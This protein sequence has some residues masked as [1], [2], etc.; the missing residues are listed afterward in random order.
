MLARLPARSADGRNQNGNKHPMQ[1]TIKKF[2]SPR[3]LLSVIIAATVFSLPQAGTAQ[4]AEPSSPRPAAQTEALKAP[5]NS[6]QGPFA[7]VDESPAQIVKI[8]ETLTGK[9]AVC[10]PLPDAKICFSSP[11]KITR[12]EA[13]RALTSLLAANGIALTPF[14]EK[15]FKVSEASSVSSQSPLWLEKSALDMP[16]SLQYYTKIYTLSYQNVADLKD[17]ITP[18]ITPKVS[19]F[20][21]LERIN[22]FM[23]TDTLANHQTVEK[24][25][26]KLDV[27]STM[28]EEIGFITLR[29]MASDDFKRKFA[30]LKADTLKKYFDHTTV[31]SDE[32]TNQIIVVTQKGNLKNIEEIIRQLDI[33]AKPLTSSKVFY[34]KCGSAKDIENVLNGIIKGQQNAVKANNQTAAQKAAAQNRLN[35]RQNAANNAQGAKKLPTNLK[36]DPNG[37]SLQFSEY[38]TIV[39][40]ERSNSIVAYGTPSDLRQ[41]GELIDG[42]DVVLPQVKIDVIIAEV[43]LT[44]SQVSGLS[45]FGLDYTTIETDGK[46]G[47]SGN[48]KTP[49]PEGQSSPAF[50]ISASEYGFSSVFSIAETNKNVRI[51][52]APSIVTTHNEEASIVVSRK[53]PF[54]TGSTTYNSGVYPSTSS[55]VD[56]RDVGI[57]LYVTPQIGDNG[58][59]Q[60][61]AQQI[62][63][64]VV[65]SVHIDNN[66]QKV[67]GRREAKSNVSAISGETIILAG[68]QQE[69]TTDDDGAVWLLSDLPLI[70]DWFKP[71]NY[72]KERTE[73][74][75]FIRPTIIKSSST[76]AAMK[77]SF[78][79]KS[80]VSAEINRYFE[81]G[82]FHDTDKKDMGRESG[83][84]SSFIR[85][86][87][88]ADE[89]TPDSGAEESGE[90]AAND[91]PA[92]STAEDNAPHADADMQ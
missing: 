37:A 82:R 51:L 38:V 90:P 59:I 85:T 15:F 41:I 24:L 3:N 74:I 69:S 32:R 13:V 28:G 5:D 64:M 54:I 10:A 35:A 23:L 16:Q 7:I 65:G 42:V 55:T 27:P 87:Y 18:V 34:I 83:R 8:L 21:P 77:N 53:Y 62:S 67:I 86:I 61:K 58:V 17:R 70:G 75:F 48:T 52:S 26:E 6:L 30:A 72:N 81:T 92:N 89:E 71:E 66:E 44:D 20:T 2:A 60:I 56:W 84:T 25:L 4:D 22:S 68:L 63:S 33:D 57:E 78:V 80:P 9:I 31:E 39:S 88:K 43:T 46:K 76:A 40:D 36:A 12:A 11:A 49:V 50:S 19:N 91:A 45:T 29:N 47:F 79:G 73:I 14:G 1:R